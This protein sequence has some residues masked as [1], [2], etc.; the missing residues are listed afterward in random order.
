MKLQGNLLQPYQGRRL[1]ATLLAAAVC[2][3]FAGLGARAAQVSLWPAR[4]YS[5]GVVVAPP[6]RADLVDRNGVLLA[7]LIPL[8]TLEAD[9]AEI[10]DPKETA[11][12]LAQT[13]PQLDRAA[14]LARLGPRKGSVILA[15]R[16]SPE[17]KEAV[18]GLGLPGIRLQ[19]E[20]R[21]FYPQ[22]ELGA[23]LIGIAD[24][25]LVGR[26]GLERAF[27]RELAGRDGVVRCSVD[28]R[29]QHAVETELARAVTASEA[30]YGAGV[31][32]D[33]Q[34]GEVLAL[35][36]APSFDANR[37]PPANADVRI[38][39]ALGAVYEMGSTMKPLTVAM[40]LDSGL[41]TPAERFSLQPLD[42]AGRT[43]RDFEPTD[44]PADLRAI[45][46]RSSN[47]GAAILAQRLGPERQQSYLKK[48]GLVDV[49]DTPI[50]EAARPIFPSTKDAYTLSAR[51]FGHGISVSMLALAQ[52]YTVFV[53]QGQVAALRFE[54][55][56]VG[57]PP[58]LRPV[59]SAQAAMQVLGYLRSNVEVGTGRRANLRAFAMGGKTGTAEKFQDGG[60]DASRNF[61][62][63]AAVFPVEAPR[64]VL[65]VGLDEPHGPNG[66]TTGGAVAAPLAA[67][68][69]SRIGP[70]LGL[71]PTGDAALAALEEQ[72]P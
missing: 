45:L 44:A 47:V 71:A 17:Q 53:N 14:L 62:S 69:G 13:L 64:Y 50:A 3:G 9:L 61:S 59:F 1:R 5:G 16:L 33:G 29:L 23:H 39:R 67:R 68:I 24:A 70:L 15:R 12:A 10:W 27:E 18:F 52:A 4:D 65:L 8:F 25:K 57:D 21:R 56:L 19:E 48:L 30:S 42:V 35:A 66:E 32:L 54:P 7:T 46:T 51:G 43:I 6:K 28:V 22:G 38:D 60:Y 31:L 58:L 36:T 34:T 63:F 2:A 26:A 41:T 72:A 20:P 49:P 11:E 37:P 55:L 40:A